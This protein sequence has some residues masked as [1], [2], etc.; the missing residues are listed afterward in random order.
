MTNETVATGTLWLARIEVRLKGAVVDPQGNTILSAL[1]QLH[2]DTVDSVR[3]GKLLEVQLHATDETDAQAK[4]EA[5]CTTLLANPVI[6]QFSF[7][8]SRS[9]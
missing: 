6:E 4:V 1:Q 8:I 5:M 7:Q 2:F 9:E 3:M